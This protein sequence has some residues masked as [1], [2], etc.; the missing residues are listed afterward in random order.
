MEKTKKLKKSIKSLE[1]NKEAHL[2]KLEKEPDSVPAVTGYW[3][4][5]I[6]TFERNI[7]KLKEKLKKK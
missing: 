1:K 5:E 4:K 7:E 6:F 3:E 2:S